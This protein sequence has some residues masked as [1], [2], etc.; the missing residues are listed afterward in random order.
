MR[1]LILLSILAL[2]CTPD[3]PPAPTLTPATETPEPPPVEPPPLVEEPPPELPL[4]EARVVRVPAEDRLELVGDLREGHAPNAPLVILVHQLST[5]RNEWEPLLRRLGGAPAMTT[6]ALDM[7]GHGE[8]TVRRD[9]EVS[10]NDFET[11]D[12]EK[13]ADDILRVLTHLREAE[14]LA[15]TRVILV[16]SSIGSSAVIVAA[17]RDESIDAVVALSPGRAYR[18]VDALTPTG[19]LGERPLLAIASRGE[20]ASA[21]TAADMAR[22]AGSGDSLLVEGDRHGVAM[23]ESA[24][25]SL[26]RVVEFLREQGAR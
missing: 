21:E 15:P 23:F 19:A 10:W 22:I 8:S 18:G 25:E 7:R 11:A 14:E 4:P 26:E 16:G 6:F 1:S 2:A 3:P 9:R 17:S 13:V 12:W 5:N 20:A 24:P